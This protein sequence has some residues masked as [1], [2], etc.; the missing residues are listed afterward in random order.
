MSFVRCL[1][2][3]LS[4]IAVY[5]VICMSSYLVHFPIRTSYYRKVVAG[6]SVIEGV[7]IQTTTNI[8]YEVMKQQG[9]DG[10]KLKDEHEVV[11]G[12]P[13]GPPVIEGNSI[14][15][16][17]NT[18]YE[19]IKQ[20]GQGEDLGDYEVIICPPGGPPPIVD[21]DPSS[22]NYNYVPVDPPMATIHHYPT[23]LT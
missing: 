20:L 17:Y 15:T 6:S 23:H 5:I 12:P 3:P 4:E 22:P 13:G 1:E 18:A 14:P 8:V 10:E 9:L 2:S 16:T 21:D 19:A 11:G 7:S